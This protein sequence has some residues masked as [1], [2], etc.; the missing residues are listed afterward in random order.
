MSS[1][2]VNPALTTGLL[3]LVTSNPGW[4]QT[5]FSNDAARGV[6]WK[7]AREIWLAFFGNGRE[8]RYLEAMAE[9]GMV[10]T[11][12]VEGRTPVW[13]ATAAW[14]SATAVRNAVEVRLRAWVILGS[15]SPPPAW[16]IV[17]HAI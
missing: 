10:Q 12:A 1:W 15:R 8:R 17:G 3:D 14:N 11:E 4:R 7:E 2:N 5:F 13:K 9:K 16:S 6:K